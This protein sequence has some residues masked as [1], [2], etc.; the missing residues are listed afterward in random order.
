MEIVQLI[1]AEDMK[2]ARRNS[3]T[4]SKLPFLSCISYTKCVRF[5]VVD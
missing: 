5:R 1:E 3:E 4:K 2:K